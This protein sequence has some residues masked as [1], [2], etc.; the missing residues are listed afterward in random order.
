MDVAGLV[1]IYENTTLID[2]F[3]TMDE[4]VVTTDVDE[5]VD[6]PPDSKNL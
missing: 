5:V 4:V 3:K 6:I 1:V 2:M